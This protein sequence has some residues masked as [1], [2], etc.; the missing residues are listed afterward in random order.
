MQWA[1]VDSNNIIQNIIAYDGIA[2]YIPDIGLVLQQVND[3]LGIDSNISDP[4]PVPLP[5][6]DLL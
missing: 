5:P 4:R 6:G 3:W 1:L 2:E